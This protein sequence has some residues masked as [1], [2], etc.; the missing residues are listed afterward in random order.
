MEI[1]EI[2][3]E[4]IKQAALE[5]DGTCPFPPDGGECSWMS[6]EQCNKCLEKNKEV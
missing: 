1:T 5:F 3:E 6:V 2:T 4:M